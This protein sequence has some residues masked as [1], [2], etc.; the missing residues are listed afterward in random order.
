MKEYNLKIPEN[1]D[2]R[3]RAP[4][5]K[6]TF[7]YDKSFQNNWQKYPKFVKTTISVIIYENEDVNKLISNLKKDYKNA[8]EFEVI[9]NN[10]TK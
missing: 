2:S 6:I 9:L 5:G 10:E 7:T 4:V 3:R 1:T 8:R